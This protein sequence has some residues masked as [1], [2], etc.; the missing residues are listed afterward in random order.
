MNKTENLQ[1]LEFSSMRND[2]LRHFIFYS[3]AIGIVG[4][5]ICNILNIAICLRK[6]IRQKM[7]G[8][9]NV[10]ISTWNILTL[11]FGFIFYFPPTIHA[12]DIVLLSI[13]ASH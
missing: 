4:F 11:S 9:Y 2:I 7:M 10:V 5:I 13:G 3:C 12:K 1:A 6:K 8:F